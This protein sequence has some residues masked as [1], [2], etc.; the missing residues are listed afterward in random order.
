MYHVLAEMDDNHLMNFLKLCAT[1][2]GFDD[3]LYL[4]E[5]INR[6]L[7]QQH[8]VARMKYLMSK[9]EVDQE[10]IDYVAKLKASG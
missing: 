8:P 3:S 6:G 10:L 2:K 9:V 4:D 5:A 7:I 1:W